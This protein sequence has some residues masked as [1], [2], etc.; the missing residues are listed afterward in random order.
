MKNI[1]YILFTLLIT[2][3]IALYAATAEQVMSKVATTAKSAKGISAVFTLTNGGK[4]MNGNLK[5]SGAKFALTT[6][7][8]ANWYNGKNMW[9]YNAASRET[10]IIQPTKSELAE[11]NPFEYLKSYGKD[12]TVSFSA[13][14]AV[15]KYIVN[16]TPKS[17][18]NQVKQIE[19]T[20]NSKTLQPEIFN[21]SLK[22]GGITKIA[23][24]SLNYKAAV[25]STDFEY[26][27][28]K[29]PKA[30]IIDLR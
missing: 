29:F 25:K 26:P 1:K 8:V 17:K 30:Q 10:T 22:S 18:K 7:A 14:K 12:Y 16:L 20:I 11:T 24:K 9:T 19:I 13:K 3:P 23:V 15:G 4:V 6:Q 21:I 2:L 5:M 28:S 27:K